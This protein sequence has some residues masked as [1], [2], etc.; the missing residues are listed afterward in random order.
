MSAGT[1]LGPPVSSGEM[2]MLGV[3]YRTLFDDICDLDAPSYPSF[4]TRTAE[5][6]AR[7]MSGT[8]S[9]KGS[10]GPRTSDSVV[11]CSDC[12]SR[13][14][15]LIAVVLDCTGHPTQAEIAFVE[16]IGCL[17]CSTAAPHPSAAS[18]A[19]FR[20]LEVDAF[21]VNDALEVTS[22]KLGLI[23]HADV[24][25]LAAAGAERRAVVS[26]LGGHTLARV[27]RC[28]DAVLVFP[29]ARLGTEVLLRA[30]AR[31]V[32]VQR[33]GPA[34]LVFDVSFEEG[35]ALSAPKCAY[36][37]GARDSPC[38]I[39]C[40]GTGGG[41]GTTAAADACSVGIVRTGVE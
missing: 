8:P 38:V 28:G 17:V 15:A 31:T 18:S 2:I 21:V 27:T 22:M 20:K 13:V 6:G 16:T 19:A 4:I 36:L 10:L 37:F 9:S 26:A 29:R 24:S 11:R 25:T 12:P 32:E 23:R 30:G 35:V 40:D 34:A 1:T 7:T 41:G 33:H 5:R 14:N 39:N 3:P